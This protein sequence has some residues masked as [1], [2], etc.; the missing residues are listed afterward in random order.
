[1][2]YELLYFTERYS[3][4]VREFTNKKLF[5][6]YNHMEKYEKLHYIMISVKFD[7][8]NVYPVK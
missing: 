1:V 3:K 2:L 7:L 4:R 5:Y 6:E 8:C